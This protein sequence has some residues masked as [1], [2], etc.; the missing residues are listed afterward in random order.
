MLLKEKAV[1]ISSIKQILALK[2]DKVSSL[3]SPYI[4]GYANSIFFRLKGHSF[5]KSEEGKRISAP[6]KGLNDFFLY[7]FPL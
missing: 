3:V 5:M 2:Q 6:L 1:C 7:S 4:K